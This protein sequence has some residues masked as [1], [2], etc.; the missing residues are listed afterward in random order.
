VTDTDLILRHID[1]ASGL[2][3]RRVDDVFAQLSTMNGSVKTALLDAAAARIVA[4][5]AELKVGQVH[6]SNKLLRTE[7]DKAAAGASAV[8]QRDGHSVRQRDVILIILAAG[9]LSSLVSA[10]VAIL[11]FGHVLPK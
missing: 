5:A 9:L 3:H 10:L 11:Y 8:Q 4:D 2:I 1:T 7:F 6:E